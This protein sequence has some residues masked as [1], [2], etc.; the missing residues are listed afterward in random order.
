MDKEQR[1]MLIYKSVTEEENTIRDTAK[2]FGLSEATIYRVLKKK[3]FVGIKGQKTAA[4]KTHI[5]DIE[6]KLLSGE[7]YLSLSH[8]YNYSYTTFRHAVN[9]LLGYLP[10]NS[11]SPKINH[12]MFN[13]WSPELEYLCGA[14][15]SDGTL[16]SNE[17]TV[18]I[19]QKER[20]W[21]EL[22]GNLVKSEYYTPTIY[23]YETG[24]PILSISS[25]RLYNILLNN[26]I[27]RNKASSL[28][29]S[30]D[31]A[32]SVY[33]WRGYFEG[34]GG[35][36]IKSNQVWANVTSNSE[37]ILNQWKVFLSKNSVTSSKIS[38][39]TGISL[40]VSTRAKK[41][42]KKLFNL[43]YSD[44]LHLV[45][46]RKYQNFKNMVSKIDFNHNLCCNIDT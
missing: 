13:S 18:R 41:E 29:V 9:S 8:H 17:V 46:P 39:S 31:L 11:H 37:D 7:S 24:L 3:G 20:E 43:L 12:E 30:K 23:E 32:D 45:H 21:L 15:A 10:D 35:V 25:K 34:D 2:A 14:I 16:L 5:N 6:E 28:K 40:K 1:N 42:I 36:S 33:F 26:G 27:T 38:Q 44:R 22:L 4:L 19:I